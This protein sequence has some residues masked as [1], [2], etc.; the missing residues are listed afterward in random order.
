MKIDIAF[1][2][3]EVNIKPNGFLTIREVRWKKLLETNMRLYLTTSTVK[4]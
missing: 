2:V 4:S 1:Y 3:F